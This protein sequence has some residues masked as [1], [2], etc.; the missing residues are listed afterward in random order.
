MLISGGT[1]FL[2]TLAIAGSP[3]TIPPE[4]SSIETVVDPLGARN[5]D[6]GMDQGW[7]APTALTQPAGT[8]TLQDHELVV[9]A[10][11]W[12]PIERLQVTVA[13]GT[14]PGLSGLLASAKVRVFDVGRF[15]LALLGGGAFDFHEFATGKHVMGGAAA[16]ACLSATCGALVSVFGMAGPYWITGT[17]DDGGPA[18]GIRIL[19]GANAFIPL[20]QHLKLLLEVDVEG[21]ENCNLYCE[22]RLFEAIMPMAGVRFH[23]GGFAAMLGLAFAGEAQLSS[24]PGSKTSY[25][26]TP[27]PVM[28]LSYRP[29]GS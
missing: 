5:A 10:A 17:R 11:T 8:F 1:A 16:S 29:G 24:M 9:L 19:F 13:G 26:F 28:N 3:A 23:T 6:S 14:L 25:A 21:M 22:S 27:F 15:H 12:A 2:A 4:T 7:L 18:S 20:S